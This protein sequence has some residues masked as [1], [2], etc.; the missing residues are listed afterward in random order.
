MSNIRL[1]TLTINNL[2]I[3]VGV[4]FKRNRYI[5]DLVYDILLLFLKVNK[6]LIYESN[7]QPI[8]HAFFDSTFATNQTISLHL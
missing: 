3:V 4:I 8:Q 7:Y 6:N 2:K 5:L 1:L